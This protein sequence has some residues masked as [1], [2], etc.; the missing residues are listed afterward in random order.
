MYYTHVKGVCMFFVANT[1]Q[2]VSVLCNSLLVALEDD[3]EDIKD[4]G[5]HCLLWGSSGASGRQARRPRRPSLPD[6]SRY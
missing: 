1:L 2:S 4:S 6:S 5:V 3:K